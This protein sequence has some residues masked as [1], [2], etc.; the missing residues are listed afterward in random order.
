M[1]LPLRILIRWSVDDDVRILI[2]E[3]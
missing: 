3:I 1:I 2:F